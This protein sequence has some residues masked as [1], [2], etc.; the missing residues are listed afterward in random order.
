MGQSPQISSTLDMELF[1]EIKALADKES[2]SMSSMVSILLAQA[3]K[4]RNRKKKNAKE[5]NP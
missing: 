1:N 3:I 4:E 5:D 2:R